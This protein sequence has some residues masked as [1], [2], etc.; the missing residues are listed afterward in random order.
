MNE[1]LA[2]KKAIE[3]HII[4]R[5]KLDKHGNCV[6]FKAHIVAKGFL[7]VLSKDFSETFSSVAKF[8]TLWVFLTLVAY[9]DFKIHQVNIVAVYLQ[10]DLDKEIYMTIP[11]SISKFGSEG[12]YWQLHKILY[13]LK[14]ADIM[15]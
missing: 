9:L 4:F 6:K 14:Q 11:E 12:Q 3:S 2:S 7:Q 8:T 1:L 5:E 15:T 10:D 13:G